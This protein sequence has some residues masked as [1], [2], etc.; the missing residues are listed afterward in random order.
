MTYASGPY[1]YGYAPPPPPPKPGVIPLAPLGLGQLLTGVFST[2]G[3]Y[4]KPLVG[5]AAAAYAAATALVGGALLLAW[6]AVADDVDRLSRLPEGKEPAFAD[7]QPLLVAFGA[8]WLT[9]VAALIVA[10]GLVHAATPAVTQ[11]AVLGRPVRFGAVW[12]RAWSRLGSVLG[13]VLLT[14]LAAFLPMVLFLAGFFLLMIGMIMGIAAS[15]GGGDG[16]AGPLIAGLLLFLAALGTFPLGVWLWVKYSLA[17]AAAVVEG[18]GALA[19]LRRSSELVRG[20]WWRIF[21]CTMITGMIVAVANYVVQQICS[22]LSFF[23]MSAMNLEPGRGPAEFIGTF[24]GLIAFLM[25][26]SIAAQA[27]LAPLQPLTSA[28]LY[29]DQ[30]IR[31]ENL[32]PLLA[33]TAAAEAP[34]SR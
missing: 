8:V 27:V 18:L 5:V 15:E 11:E 7:V 29:V 4:W 23:P 2:F 6:N 30:R 9:G 24:A 17:P 32:G 21:S 34:T 28:L 25:V 10:G 13:S 33:Q 22:L 26:V 31:K 20:S 19:A 16:G 12:S 1:G 3:R 14:M